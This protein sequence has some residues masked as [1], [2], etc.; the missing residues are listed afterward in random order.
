MKKLLVDDFPDT[1]YLNGPLPVKRSL[2]VSNERLY[3]PSTFKLG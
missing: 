1:L 3:K 2:A